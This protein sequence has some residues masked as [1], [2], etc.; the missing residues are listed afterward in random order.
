MKTEFQP[1]KEGLKM[2]YNKFD[3]VVIQNFDE[4]YNNKAGVIIE[5]FPDYDIEPVYLVK[6]DLPFGN[7][8]KG[9]F[10]ESYLNTVN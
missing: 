1:Y 2:K 9:M 7:N 3:K 8:T 5:V 10:K 4:R 6:Y